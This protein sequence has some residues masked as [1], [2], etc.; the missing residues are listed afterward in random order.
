VLDEQ[1]PDH[2]KCFK[3]AAEINKHR[4]AAAWGINKKEAE[5]KAAMNALAELRGETA[6]HPADF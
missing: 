1:G 3:V 6:P 2:N 4:Y 5:Q